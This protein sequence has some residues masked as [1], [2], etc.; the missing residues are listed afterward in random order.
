MEGSRAYTTALVA[1]LKAAIVSV[2]I[3]AAGRVFH[4]GTVPTKK[5]CL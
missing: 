3:A 5:E 1:A 4:I 2:C